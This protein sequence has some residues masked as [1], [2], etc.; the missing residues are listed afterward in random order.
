[1]P[2]YRRNYRRNGFRR[3]NNSSESRV[4]SSLVRREV[5]TK[6]LSLKTYTITPGICS[7]L[8][9]QTDLA[10]FGS[11]GKYE[12]LKAE[13]FEDGTRRA[14]FGL[15]T[16][17]N[18]ESFSLNCALP[19]KTP[20]VYFTNINKYL[21]KKGIRNTSSVALFLGIFLYAVVNCSVRITVCFSYVP[22][23]VV[24]NGI[25]PSFLPRTFSNEMNNVGRPLQNYNLNGF[26]MIR[27]AQLMTR[28]ELAEV[29]EFQRVE[30]EIAE[31]AQE[32]FDRLNQAQNV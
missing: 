6:F 15:I 21:K 5:R 18:A 30:E 2:S 23:P 12:Y 7:T 8:P 29:A 14:S 16:D 17:H 31:R 11:Y 24:Q 27:A 22:H 10:A 20:C 28:A 32:M 13:I 19:K 9:L 1:M 25:S 26:D 4:R 3:F